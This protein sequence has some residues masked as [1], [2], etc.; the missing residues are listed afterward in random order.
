MLGRHRVIETYGGPYTDAEVVENP[1]IEQ[2]ADA[3]NRHAEDTAIMS[4]LTPAWHV[5][6]TLDSASL[7][8]V[9]LSSASIAVR[10]PG[11]NS[12]D[13][14]PTITKDDVGT[15]TL[16]FPESFTDSLG[17][18]IDTTIVGAVAQFI[19]IDG[20]TAHVTVALSNIVG[21]ETR[22]FGSVADVDGEV[23]VMVA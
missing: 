19:G 2:G 18:T 4:R 9:T 3:Y 6:F 7:A 22:S 16:V 10:G 15:Y 13:M 14:K 23:Y 12:N 5:K 8:P 11:G 1:E 17:E 21:I 20:S